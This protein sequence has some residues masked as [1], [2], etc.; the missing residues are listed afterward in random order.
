MKK[1]G[2]ILFALIIS[3]IAGYRISYYIRDP[4]IVTVYQDKIITNTITKNVNDMSCEE[5]KA[6][7]FCFYT[8]F[9]TLA[10]NHIEGDE[11]LQSA[12]LCER[13]WSRQTTIESVSKAYRNMVIAGVFFDSQM[14]LGFQSQYYRFYGRFGIGGGLAWTQGYGQINGGIAFVW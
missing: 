1:D 14:R 13:K 2:F 12:S 5:A 6:D 3:F 8:G 10:I 7:L 4:K 9:P 11:Y